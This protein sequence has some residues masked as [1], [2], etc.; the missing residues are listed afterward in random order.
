MYS[1]ITEGK[2]QGLNAFN[3]PG[4]NIKHLRDTHKSEHHSSRTCFIFVPAYLHSMKSLIISLVGIPL[5]S[6]H[7]FTGDDDRSYAMSIAI[8]QLVPTYPSHHCSWILHHADNFTACPPRPGL[9]V[10]PQVDPQTTHIWDFDRLPPNTLAAFQFIKQL[11]NR[12]DSTCLKLFLHSSSSG[13]GYRR[14]LTIALWTLPKVLAVH[15]AEV[16]SF[17]PVRSIPLGDALQPHLLVKDISLL[18]AT[19]CV[20]LGVAIR[21]VLAHSD[22]D[23]VTRRHDLWLWV[24]LLQG[25]SLA[26]GIDL[27][28]PILIPVLLRLEQRD[29]ATPVQVR[30]I[31]LAVQMLLRDVAVVRCFVPVGVVDD[32]LP[33]GGPACEFDVGVFFEV[34]PY[35]AVYFGAY[36][37]FGFVADGRVFDGEVFFF[38]VAAA[39]GERFCVCSWGVRRGL[40]K[41]IWGRYSRRRILTR[42]IASR[43]SP[44]LFLATVYAQKSACEHSTPFVFDK[45][46]HNLEQKDTTYLS[47]MILVPIVQHVTFNGSSCP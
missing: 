33:V 4:G 41:G 43:S 26:L 28:R 21:K 18:H 31:R 44:C 35:V 29:R 37:T 42:R 20:G 6:L 2:T 10:H 32:D 27:T 19:F 15:I 12:L 46:A 40:R 23:E 9:P 1:S 34:S 47:P 14:V 11:V 16:D 22:I 25:L 24:T 39:V 3:K 7:H 38:G 17:A 8:V 45:H 13:G 36:A 5:L 30:D